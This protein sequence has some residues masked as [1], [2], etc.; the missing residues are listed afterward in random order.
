MLIDFTTD[1]ESKL[2]QARQSA[3]A[4]YQNLLAWLLKPSDQRPLVEIEQ[5][6]HQRLFQ[7]GAAL[8]ALWL[9]HRRTRVV[10]RQVRGPD[11]RWYRH[12]R[13]GKTTVK[14]L[15]GQV[16][17]WRSVYVCGNSKGA[18]WAPLD[19]ELGLLK[20]SFSL[21]L[22]GLA[23]YFCS[24]MAFAEAAQTLKQCGYFAPSTKSLQTMVDQVAPLAPPFVDEQPCPPDDGE[25]L[26]IE[27]DGRGAPMI[28]E[29]EMALRK[30]EQGKRQKRQDKT[31]R[32]R[33]KQAPKDRRSRG[34][35]SK[36]AKVAMVGVLY[37]LRQ[38]ADGIESPINKRVHAT[39]RS[40]RQLFRW[41]QAEAIKRG[42]GQKRTLFMADG[43]WGL[44]RLQEEYFPL[45]E[46][47]VDWYH[48]SEKLWAVGTTLHE[49]GSEKLKQWVE[50]QLKDLREGRIE[51]L[52]I[53]LDGLAEKMSK[54]KRERMAQCIKYLAYHA[55]RLR[56]A[57]LRAE[58]LPIGTGV[59]EGAVRQLVAM[60]LDGPGMRWSPARA[61]HVLQL[62]A[63]VINGMWDS[64]MAY[65]IERAHTEGL[66]KQKP[67][68]LGDTHTA[69]RR[70][71][72]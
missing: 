45:A 25:I 29:S 21:H 49:E 44:W 59:V 16:A 53:R 8:L 57:E 7:L 32:K 51:E 31:V 24:K 22:I 68:G 11:G 12:E 30:K 15:F 48:V 43:A 23:T 58:G 69:K 64:F 42:Y 26:V 35:K 19:K 70:A 37:T 3:D 9:A 17:L 2:A 13:V 18:S 27:I 63:M 60:R 10:E 71:H 52:I 40:A 20:T 56:Y 47:C 6:L 72:A 41:V 5:G 28:S 14:T 4:E 36:N 61:E 55:H 67:Q 34:E 54:K 50:E 46:V 38:T 66:S 62:R 1:V 65:V 39:F 33:R